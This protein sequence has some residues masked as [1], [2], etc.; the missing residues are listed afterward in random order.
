MEKISWSDGVKNLV[1][2]KDGQD[3]LDQWSEKCGAGEGWRRS[4]GR[5]E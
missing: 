1:L 2:E 5:M 4:V 3:Q